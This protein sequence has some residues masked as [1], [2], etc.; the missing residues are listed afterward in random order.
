MNNNIRGKRAK[1]IIYDD[2]YFYLSKLAEDKIVNFLSLSTYEDLEKYKYI[3]KEIEDNTE[4]DRV[5]EWMKYYNK[6]PIKFVEDCLGV[7]LK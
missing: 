5:E 4:R 1:I 2:Y 6:Y 7:K 3:C